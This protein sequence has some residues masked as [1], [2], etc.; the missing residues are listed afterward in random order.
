MKK[1]IFNADDFGYCKSV[2][3]AIIDSFKFGLL[4]S[5]T[6]MANMPGFEQAVKL[7]F[8]NQ[9]LDVGVHLTLTCGAPTTRASSLIVPE[10]G[11]FKKISFY[12]HGDFQ[13][14]E[15]EVYDEF[16]SQ[17]EKVMAAGIN[18]SHLDSHQHVHTMGV[19][20]KITEKLAT[21]YD[22]PIRNNASTS[23]KH[24]ITQG[25]TMV[26]DD[27]SMKISPDSYYQYRDQFIRDLKSQINKY[28]SIEVMTHPGYL[29]YFVFRNS[30]F[31]EPRAIDAS[32][33]QDEVVKK[34]LTDEN[35]Q[36]TN[37][38]NF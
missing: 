19:I 2:N 9:K 29:D 36:I 17:I 21:E 11:L 35:Y 4:K 25:F 1:I 23:G 33:L 10:T 22:I 38:K 37:F 3:Y 24:F 7:Y 8:E 18:P 30:S 20:K 15:S 31:T 26:M 32:F 34:A 6:I 28:D 13:I 12:D 16:K 27:Y 5:T 14:D